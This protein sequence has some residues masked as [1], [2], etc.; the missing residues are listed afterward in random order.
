MWFSFCSSWSSHETPGGNNLNCSRTHLL[1]ILSLQCRRE[2]IRQTKASK[3]TADTFF[4]GIFSFSPQMNFIFWPTWFHRLYRIPM[5]PC[6]PVHGRFLTQLKCVCSAWPSADAKKSLLGVSAVGRKKKNSYKRNCERSSDREWES[7]SDCLQY[8]TCS[9]VRTVFLQDAW[10]TEDQSKMNLHGGKIRSLDSINKHQTHWLVLKNV[11]YF[12]F[13]TLSRLWRGGAEATGKHNCYS[14][15][16]LTM[17][18]VSPGNSC[19]LKKALGICTAVYSSLGLWCAQ[20]S[21]VHPINSFVLKVW[22]QLYKL[23][24]T[25]S[26]NTLLEGCNIHLMFV[27]CSMMFIHSFLIKCMI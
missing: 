5:W 19:S 1:F 4:Q 25:F 23:T 14:S 21:V 8:E 7:G 10:E 2:N 17:S 6:G 11:V 18:C 27:K 15:F 9:Y 16:V 24:C 20:R 13:Q 12:R 26:Q 22:L 3:W